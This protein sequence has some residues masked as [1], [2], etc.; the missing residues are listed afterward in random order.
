LAQWRADV[1]SRRGAETALIKFYRNLL[2]EG[3][4]GNAAEHSPVAIGWQFQ[5]K[6]GLSW[7]KRALPAVM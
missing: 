2:L 3:I 5:Q 1:E 4:A 7:V 6:V